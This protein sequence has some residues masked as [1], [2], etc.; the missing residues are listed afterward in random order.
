[1]TDNE[2]NE[3]STVDEVVTTAPDFDENF[4]DFIDEDH[5]VNAKK[6][7]ITFL[8]S[9]IVIGGALGG[10]VFMRYQATQQFESVHRSV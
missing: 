3:E 5:P 8:L 4:D 1:M 10:G 2:L 9:V 7:F 6:G